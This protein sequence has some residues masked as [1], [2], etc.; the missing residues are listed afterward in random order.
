MPH[1]FIFWIAFNLF[2]LVMLALDLGVFQRK[3]HVVRF[4]EALGWTLVWVALAALFA[5]LLYHFGQQMAGDTVLSNGTLALQFITGYVIELSLSIDNLFVF[6]LLFRFFHVPA[7]LQRGVLSWGIVGA[8]IMR[9][10]FILAGVALIQRFEWITYLFGAFLIYAGIK[11]VFSSGEEAPKENIAIRLFRRMVP[12]TTEFDG[13]KFF[14]LKNGIRCATP[15]AVVLL[16][17]ETTDLLF[18]VD[19]IPAVLAISRDAFIVYTSN[20][21]AILGLRSMYFALA[22][23]MDIFHLLHYG[24]SLVLIFIGVKMLGAHFFDIPIGLSLGIVIGILAAAVVLSLMI[25]KK[26]KKHA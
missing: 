12:V 14:T 15:L 11:L 17:V 5:L 4:R 20:V 24:L 7:E 18:A 3:E 26:R 10:V 6:L 2:V 19:S 8:L 13:P 16:M 21:F 1:N 23:L 22:G 25:P 9:A